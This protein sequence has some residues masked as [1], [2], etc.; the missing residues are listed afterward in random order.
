M[1]DTDLVGRRIRR[2]RFEEFIARG[3]MGAI[4]LGIDE[5]L[6]RKVALKV[7]KAH[8][9]LEPEEK[10]RFLREARALSKLQHPNISLIHDYVDEGDMEVLVLELIQGRSLTTP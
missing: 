1:M 7:I 9:R 4:Y 3:G 8:R 6:E 5:M 2:Y 10:S